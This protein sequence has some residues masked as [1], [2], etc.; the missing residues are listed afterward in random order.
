MTQYEAPASPPI[1][2]LQPGDSITFPAFRDLSRFENRVANNVME[3]CQPSQYQLHAIDWGA[4]TALNE[5]LRPDGV[6]KTV[7][8]YSLTLLADPVETIVERAGQKKRSPS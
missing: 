5:L 3:K 6:N 7:G 4:R 8:Q 1:L 2:A